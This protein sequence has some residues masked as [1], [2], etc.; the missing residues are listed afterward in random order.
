MASDPSET[1]SLA[2]FA[3]RAARVTAF[4]LPLVLCALTAST[5]P[6]WLDS[7][8][9]TAAAQTLG[10][11]HPP[12]HPLFVLLTKPFTLLPVGGVAFRVAL[13]SA[14][15]LAVACLL[16]HLLAESVLAAATPG[17]PRPA[18][19]AVA[20]FAALVAAAAPG[21][22]FQGVR[23]EVYALQIAC[24]L[25]AVT[26]LVRSTLSRD[27]GDDRLLALAAFAYGLGLANHHFISLVALPA[28]IV[29]LVALART[30]GGLGALAT[31]GRLALVALTGLLPYALLPI[32]SAAGVPIS[33][34]GVRGP[35]DFLWVV[36]ARAYQK[37]MAREHAA[38]LQERSLDALFTMMSELTPVLVIVAL[39]GFYLLVRRRPTR[40]AGAILALLAGVTVLLR[41][42][43]GFD[44][45]NPDYYGYMLPA[46]AAL[47]VGAAV[48]AAVAADVLSRALASGEW[49]R[50][51]LAAALV[52]GLLAFPVWRAR[53][54]YP[55]VD[56]SD[57]RATRLF[58][59]LTF[60]GVA[61]GSLVLTAYY[62]L[63]F[64]LWSAR[65]IDGTR[66]DVTVV[67]PH[68]F[69]YPGYLASTL[70]AHPELKQLAWS[71]VVEGR[72][73][74]SAVAALALEGPLR[75]EPD[76]LLDPAA[77]RFLLPDGPAY[78]ASPE[79]LAATDVAA[80]SAAHHERWRRFYTRL[81]PDWSDHETW[82]MLSWCH[83]LDA[84]FLARRGDRDG[85]RTAVEMARALGSEAPQLDG[86]AAALADEKER[87]PLDVS[88]YLPEM[89]RDA[90]GD[91][92]E[93]KEHSE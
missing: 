65:H 45:Y 43:M 56:L 89:L 93:E 9:L 84:L 50:R 44:P 32:R 85:A 20:L 55:R 2:D 88:P 38:T 30:R 33:L 6:Y 51:A 66:P 46:V 41:A 17:L 21:W 37:S 62:K 8:E 15:F 26:P 48:F 5:E 74:E 11:A 16:L 78:A 27:R 52:V 63:F 12:G 77:T 91:G 4:G 90:A 80:A 19:S 10:I 3:V 70:E 53:V 92:E 18:R 58:V 71:M 34:G 22:W 49:A 86:L 57:F 28:L 82:R 1:P 7:P 23:A 61:P 35:G 36:S 40:L 87:G 47:A 14:L 79:P 60:D 59:D 42:V 64:V 73:T 24:V 39:G 68:L 83:Y 75:V 81:G 72:L 76:P 29:P 31:T 13:A 54:A 67:N 25:A 69:G